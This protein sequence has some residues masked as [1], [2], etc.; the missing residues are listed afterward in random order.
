MPASRVRGEIMPPEL[1]ARNKSHLCRRF[2]DVILLDA[3]T[4]RVSLRAPLRRQFT[5]PEN[6]LLADR[7]ICR[8]H[9]MIFSPLYAGNVSSPGRDRNALS[10]EYLVGRRRSTSLLA[11]RKYSLGGAESGGFE[12][13]DVKGP[14]WSREQRQLRFESISRPFQVGVRDFLCSGNLFALYFSASVFGFSGGN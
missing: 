1:T 10:R 5:A 6:R 3:R 13:M 9:R 11:G 4:P 2:R 7:Q 12:R 14:R 8:M